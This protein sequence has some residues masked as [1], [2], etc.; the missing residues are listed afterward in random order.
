MDSVLTV[1]YSNWYTSNNKDYPL[2]NG[3]PLELVCWLRNNEDQIVPVGNFDRIEQLESLFFCNRPESHYYFRNSNFY[4]HCK[5][6]GIPFVSENDVT[7][8]NYVYP[9]EIESNTI[10]YILHPT[11]QYN[12]IS[13]LSDKLLTL[14]RNGTVRLLL[15]NMVDP[16]AESSVLNEVEEYFNQHGV[17]NVILLQGNIR[18]TDTNLKQ[19]ESV[20]AA[21]QTA[22]EMPRYPYTTSLG[23]VSDYVRTEDLTGDIRPKKFLSFNRFL[24]RSNRTGLAYVLLKHNLLDSGYFSF[25]CNSKDDYADRLARLDLPTDYADKIKELVPYQIDTEH[26]P[27]EELPRFFTVTNYK[28]DLY[29]NSYVHIVTETQF[30]ETAT[31]FF[32]EKTFRPI[33]NLQ[34]FIHLGNCLSLNTLRMMG[35][36]TFS[37]FINEDYDSEPNPVKRFRLIEAEIARLGNMPID[38]IHEWYYSIKD[39]LI[40]NQ[41]TLES[42]RTYNPLWQLQNIS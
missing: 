12:F 4:Y 13:T 21:F 23:Y 24:D 20:L 17:Y 36:K 35:F 42:Y 30:E 9:I 5:R 31:P 39:L 3:L 40:H 38:Q 8:G 15:V 29:Q 19:L 10:Q 25:L 34:P 32:S 33:L 11:E 41:K 28:K 18:N 14:L 27:L 2:T 7:E 22:E 1:V 26:L 16:S 37:P 6:Q